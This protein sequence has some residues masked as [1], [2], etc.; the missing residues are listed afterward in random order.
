[1]ATRDW[2]IS[3]RQS[4]VAILVKISDFAKG[5]LRQF[6][7]FIPLILFGRDGIRTELAFLLLFLFFGSFSLILSIIGYY[8]FYFSIENG[9][10]RIRK[11][12]LKKVDINLPIE[13][14]QSVNFQQGP[15]HQLFGVV[16]VEIDSAGAKGKEFEIAALDKASAEALKIALLEERSELLA[17]KSGDVESVALVQKEERQLLFQHSMWDLFKIGISQ[18]H[19]RT[20]GILLAFVFGLYEN[21]ASMLFDDFFDGVEKVLGVE[22]ESIWM[23]ILIVLPLFLIA[24]FLVTLVRTVLSEFN[25]RFWMSPR[26]FTLQGGLI[27]RKQ[28]VALLK[29]IQTVRWS[30]NPIQRTMGF[31]SLRLN[32]A[33][34]SEVAA[35]K[36][37]KI[38]G[39]YGHQLD[40]IMQHTYGALL[41]DE[42]ISAKPDRRLIYRRFLFLG[43]L[44]SLAAIFLAIFTQAYHYLVLPA[45]LPL[46]YWIQL[47]WWQRFRY[48]VGRDL[49]QVYRG[50]ITH[51][52]TILEIFK[53][54]AVQISQT[55]YQRR[56]DLASV[57]IYSASGNVT[58]PYIE[59]S[60]AQRVHD[61]IVYRAEVSDDSWM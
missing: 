39:V 13:R 46:I 8:R 27:N 23:T 35:S 16:G 28:T 17:E 43:I 55:P 59:L 38:A 2:S 20:A 57:H 47:R 32:Q 37:T 41:D 9:E 31:F 24:S 12:V 36:S 1:M 61:T 3:Q 21:I 42:V 44:P 58:L 11:G 10:F 54:Q 49:L 50:F 14:I 4:K 45:L 60:E 40:S 56:K 51:K 30:A 33:A 29:K 22:L 15:I 7:V 26:G 18:N 53:V 34:S 6:W 48:D 52:A 25:L 19:L 5:L